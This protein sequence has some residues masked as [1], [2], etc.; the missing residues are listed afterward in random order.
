MEDCRRPRG[1]AL[2]LVLGGVDMENSASLGRL[3]ELAMQPVHV[4]VVPSSAVVVTPTSNFH[5]TKQRHDLLW[6]HRHQ[7]WQC[8]WIFTHFLLILWHNS[9]YRTWLPDV[10]VCIFFSFNCPWI[11]TTLCWLEARL[12]TIL[13]RYLSFLCSARFNVYIICNIWLWI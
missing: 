8:K 1:S 3:E 4:P 13:I 10:L 5:R 7:W 12:L 9:T 11:S 6:H 2:I